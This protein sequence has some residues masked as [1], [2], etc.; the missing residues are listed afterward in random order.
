MLNDYDHLRFLQITSQLRYRVF[1]G[2][3]DKSEYGGKND[4]GQQE[5]TVFL[6]HDDLRHITLPCPLAT[7]RNS[8]AKVTA[9]SGF[10]K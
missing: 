10:R 8:V 2:L 6:S 7:A 9:K 4:R 1:L 3:I 5:K